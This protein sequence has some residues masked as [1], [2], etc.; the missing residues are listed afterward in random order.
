MVNRNNISD[1]D[2]TQYIR[3]GIAPSLVLGLGTPTRLTFTYLHQSEYN[4]PD[5][6]LPWLYIGRPGTSTA[7]ANPA[8]L[9][10]TQSNYYGFENGNYLRTNV[11]V[12]TIKLEHDFSNTL[13]LTNQLRYASYGR[14]FFHNGAADL[15]TG[16]RF[17]AGQHRGVH[18]D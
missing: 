16:Q 11:N 10:Q 14:A 18:A 1:R 6:G 8:P 15:H 3:F 7:I 9:S 5:Y 17:D 2:V 4:Q 12:P 13:T